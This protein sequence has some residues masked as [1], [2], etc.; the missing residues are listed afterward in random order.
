MISFKDPE[1]PIVNQITFNFREGYQLHPHVKP[2]VRIEYEWGHRLEYKSVRMEDIDA[3]TKTE[4]VLDVWKFIGTGSR[5]SRV[6][7]GGREL[8]GLPDTGGRD[9]AGDL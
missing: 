5:V 8:G 3:P 9:V 7:I 2:A 4:R 6:M 1:H